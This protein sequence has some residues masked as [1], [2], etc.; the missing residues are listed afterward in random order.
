LNLNVKAIFFLTRAC[1]PL[2]KAAATLEDPGRVINLGSIDGIRIPSLETYAYSASKAAVHQLTRTMA[3]RLSK[4]KITVNA[5]AAGAFY[6]RMMKATL[7][8]A[9]E[10]IR[11]NIPMGRTGS[12]TD[13]AGTAIWL[14]SRAGAWTTGSI[15]V[16]DGGH[17]IISSL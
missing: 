1:Y 15:V 10:V 2:L 16:V 9:G 5:I 12:E 4:D 3:N 11:S 13:A 8:T 17:T 7:D 14:S 6:S